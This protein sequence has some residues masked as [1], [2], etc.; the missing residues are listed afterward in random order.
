MLAAMKL[1]SRGLAIGPVACLLPPAGHLLSCGRDTARCRR[2]WPNIPRSISWVFEEQRNPRGWI[3]E[4]VP[5]K[6]KPIP[7]GRRRLRAPPL[8]R[9]SDAKDL[10]RPWPL[11]FDVENLTLCNLQAR[12]SRVSK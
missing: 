12:L 11:G 8:E 10:G 6:V 1:T 9:S 2:A 3:S 7:P 5:W 4:P